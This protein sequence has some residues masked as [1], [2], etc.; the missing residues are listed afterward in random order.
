MGEYCRNTC[1]WDE[2]KPS[3]HEDF[4]PLR[5]PW[6]GRVTAQKR[7]RINAHRPRK[8]RNRGARRYY[9]NGAY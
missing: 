1:K 7:L 3:A 6:E 4:L 5:A 8:P 9:K 2:P